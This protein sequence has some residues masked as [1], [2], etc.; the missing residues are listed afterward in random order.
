LVAVIGCKKKI[1]EQQTTDNSI[2][3]NSEY[4]FY[5]DAAS[6][7]N[8]I[9]KSKMGV[10]NLNAANK[11]GRSN[12]VANNN[13]YPFTLIGSINA[14]MVNGNATIP[15]KIDVPFTQTGNTPLPS[16]AYVGYRRKNGSFAGAI[17]IINF[18]NLG[19]PVLVQSVSLP[20][21]D[22]YQVKARGGKLYFSGS[23]NI[24]ENRALSSAGVFGYFDLTSTGTF[25]GT[26]ATFSLPVD[27]AIDFTF[28]SYFNDKAYII[29]GP[30]G[31]AGNNDS[32]LFEFNYL[33]NTIVTTLGAANN[34]YDLR[35]IYYNISGNENLSVYSARDGI[36]IFKRADLTQNSFLAQPKDSIG[37]PA[38]GITEGLV[39]GILICA[40]KNGFKALDRNSFNEIDK[41]LPPH[42]LPNVNSNDIGAFDVNQNDGLMSVSMGAAGLYLTSLSTSFPNIGFQLYGSYEFPGEV[43]YS[44]SKYIYNPANYSISYLLVATNNGVKVV[45]L[46]TSSIS[47]SSGIPVTAPC[48]NVPLYSGGVDYVLT[49]GN[50]AS[51]GGSM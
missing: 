9:D 19:N 48:N 33:T 37:W 31:Y 22:I 1:E 26:S 8:R 16:I 51:F 30:S 3:A 35:A 5:K 34:L 44:A 28:T 32:K 21:T 18:N 2:S 13:P 4:I 12:G 50:N 29:G 41:I 15:T 25:V 40:G 42:N 45:E 47:A 10:L 49:S 46:P 11:N 39:T 20:H 43:V 27:I 7:N 36:H 17:D 6:L 24:S 38:R 14:P 23:T